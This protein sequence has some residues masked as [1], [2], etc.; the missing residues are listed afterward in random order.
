MSGTVPVSSWRY[1]GFSGLSALTLGFLF[2][3]SRAMKYLVIFSGI[4]GGKSSC[5]RRMYADWTGCKV[6]EAP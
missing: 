4:L 3:H 5:A 6:H 1:I 2:L